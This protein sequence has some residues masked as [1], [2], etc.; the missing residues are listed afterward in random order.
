[1]TVVSSA[2]VERGPLARRP[3]RKPTMPAVPLHLALRQIATRSGCP[4]PGRRP[5]SPGGGRRGRRRPARRCR[6][7]V[8]PEGRGRSSRR[9]SQASNGPAI[10]RWRARGSSAFRPVL[11]VDDQ[12]AA[13]DVG[14]AAAVLRGGGYHGRPRPGSERLLQVGRGEGVVDDHRRAGAVGEVGDRRD[15]GDGE[16]RVGGVST[17]MMAVS[18]RTAPRRQRGR[19]ARRGRRQAPRPCTRA[20]SR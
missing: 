4:A 3:T 8:D 18:G 7:V 20:N 16:Q 12:R 6:S 1:M 14:V 17:Q 9:I 2:D 11:V 5:R 15:V 10:R 13:H 19:S